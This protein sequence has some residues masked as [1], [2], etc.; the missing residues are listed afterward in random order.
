M[1]V[2]LAIIAMVVLVA[3]EVGRYL[4]KENPML[5]AM[6]RFRENVIAHKVEDDWDDCWDMTTDRTQDAQ[7]SERHN[8]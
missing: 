4:L 2:L 5:G 8:P 3:G 6:R 7:N 1:S